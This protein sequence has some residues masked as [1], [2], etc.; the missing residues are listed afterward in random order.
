MVFSRGKNVVVAVWLALGVGRLRV[1][2]V[3]VMEERE[4]GREMRVKG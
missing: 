2:I 1:V 4:S 3:K